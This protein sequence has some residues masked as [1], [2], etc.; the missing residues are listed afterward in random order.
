MTSYPRSTN[1]VWHF[2][3][4]TAVQTLYGRWQKTAWNLNSEKDPLFSWDH[5]QITRLHLG[6]VNASAGMELLLKSIH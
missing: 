1:P 3:L 6:C 2:I 5:R 4:V